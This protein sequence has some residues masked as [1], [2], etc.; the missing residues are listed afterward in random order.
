MLIH[1]QDIL[2]LQ[3]TAGKTGAIT[4]EAPGFARAVLTDLLERDIAALAIRNGRID[5]GLRPS[6]WAGLRLR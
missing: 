2:R 1:L 3:E 6:G 5:V 4:V